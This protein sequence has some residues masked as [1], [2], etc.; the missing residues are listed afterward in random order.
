MNKK[1]IILIGKSA[2]GKDTLRS[3]LIEE[4]FRPAVSYTTRPI[5]PG[6]IEGVNYHF[7]SIEKFEQLEKEDF[8]I[9]SELF[10]VVGGQKWKYGKS[11]QTIEDA[12]IFIATVNGVS[13]MLKKVDRNMFHIVELECPDALR[14]MRSADRGD[15]PEEVARRLKADDL[16]FER[17]RDF[18]IDE[19]INTGNTFATEIFIEKLKNDPPTF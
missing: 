18:E 5:R 2:T 8:F 19:K 1:K 11:K 14:L 12:D 3:R 13:N 6:E 15:D 4:G 10:N 9:E 17:E 7:V 16:D